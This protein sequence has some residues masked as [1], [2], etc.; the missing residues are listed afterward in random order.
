MEPIISGFSRGERFSEQKLLVGSGV[1]EE[2][3]SFSLEGRFDLSSADTG[4]KFLTLFVLF[5]HYD[6]KLTLNYII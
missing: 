4:A 2:L 1:V 3:F 5:I 6:T